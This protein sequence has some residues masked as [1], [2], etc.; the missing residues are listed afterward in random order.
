MAFCRRHGTWCAPRTWRTRAT[1]SRLTVDDLAREARAVA[2]PLQRRVPAYLRGVAT[3]LP[4]DPPSGAGCHAAAHDRPSVAASAWMWACSSV[5][6]FTSSFRR[7]YGCSPSTYRA[8]YPAAKDLALVPACVLRASM[9]CRTTE[10]FEKPRP[11]DDP[12]IGPTV[13]YD[14]LQEEEHPMI[15]IATTQLWVHDQD[16]ALEFY[17]TKVGMEVRQDVTVPEIGELP[18]ADRLPK[19][20]PDVAIVLMAIPGA[21][22]HGPRYRCTGARPHGQGIRGHRVPDN[23]GLPRVSRRAEGTRGAVRGGA[24][25][26]TLWAGCRVP[27]SVRQPFPAD[28]AAGAGDLPSPAA[29]DGRGQDHARQF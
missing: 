25:G 28:A 26:P 2:C 19:G 29:F 27:R 9:G 3:R 13:G 11:P 10:R 20:Q 8:A 22:R 4:A 1:R 7:M 15:Q 12:S 14:R 16:E 24:R 6:S 21:A 18:L 5:G 17:T 23:G